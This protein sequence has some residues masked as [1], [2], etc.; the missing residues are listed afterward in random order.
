MKALVHQKAKAIALRQKG[1]TYTEIKEMVPVAK[2]SLSLWLKDLP[3]T[4]KE[5]LAL[6]SRKNSRI[7]HGRI[8]VAGILRSKRLIRE[9]DQ[10]IEARELFKKYQHDPFFHAG[11]NLYWAEGGKRTNQWQFMNSDAEMQQV[12]MLWLIMF[13]DIAKKDL[14]FRLYIHKPYQSEA[15]DDWWIKKLQV[16]P[17][18]FLSTVIKPS[19]LGV[20]KRPDYRGCLRIEVRSSKA[21]LNKMRFW[22]KMLVEFYIKQ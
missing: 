22:Q 12:M 10:L 11:I 9:K 20:K 19:G 4:K 8:K 21:L 2:S 13:A 14:R 18:Q 7:S 5:K 15:C 17:D 16:H 3:L 1:Y 6:K